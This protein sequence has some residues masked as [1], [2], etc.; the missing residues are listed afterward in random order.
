MIVSMWDTIPKDVQLLIQKMA[1]ELIIKDWLVD[2][3]D[4]PPPAPVAVSDVEY[5]NAE[6]TR[7]QTSI[8]HERAKLEAYYAHCPA[9][10]A[11]AEAAWLA[12][13]KADL[14]LVQLASRKQGV[15]FRNMLYHDVPYTRIR[16]YGIHC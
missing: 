11:G 5:R 7:Y 15:N 13:E 14:V 12:F 8:A 16:V 1:H 9:A 2:R 6:I 4:Y 10:S 3:A